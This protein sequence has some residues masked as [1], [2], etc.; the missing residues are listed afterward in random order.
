MN[1]DNKIVTVPYAAY[2]SMLAREDKQQR[3]MV[4]IIILLIILLVVSNVIW[5]FEWNKYDYVTE[6][7]AI[8]A[9]QGGDGVNIVG[10]GDIDY[11][12][13]S[14][15]NIQKEIESTS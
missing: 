2:E 3:R 4:I 8:D 6:D 15:Y 12:T 11:V 10:A 1:E 14:S 9:E 13:E 5:I 7:Y